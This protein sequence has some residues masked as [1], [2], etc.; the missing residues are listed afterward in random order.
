MIYRSAIARQPDQFRHALEVVQPQLR[1]L[2]LSQFKK[3]TLVVT[4]IGASYEA[5][6]V[7]TGELQRRGRRA[8]TWRAVDLVEPGDPGDSIIVL[9]V[10]GRSVEPIAALNVHSQLPSLAITNEGNDPLSRAASTAIRFESG[11]DSLPSSTGYTGSLLA[12]GLLVDA[13]GGGESFN[14]NDIPHIASEVLKTSAKK[15]ARAGEMFR[16]QR[17]IDCVG[18]ISAFGTAGEACLLIR[19]AVRVPAGASDTLHYLHGPMESM[20]QA[21]GILIFGDGREVRLAQEL[22]EIGC[23]V[24]LVTASELPRDHKGLTV[25]KVP[26]LQNRVARAIVDILPTQL[27]A[28]ELSDAAGLTDVPFR[29]SQTDTKVAM[30]EA[31]TRI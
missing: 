22:A 13:L 2:D 14:W 30:D 9:S 1:K 21:T 11:L 10:G 31:E 16:D 8:N 5:A 29:Y 28:A 26:P 20:D 25:V 17:A 24:L 18:A 4:G 23:A 3:G 7:V 6:A 27:L 12:G 15:M 19:E